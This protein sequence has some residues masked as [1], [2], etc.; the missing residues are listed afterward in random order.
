MSTETPTAATPAATPAPAALVSGDAPAAGAPPAGSSL[1]DVLY[2]ADA[3]PTADASVSASAEDPAGDEPEVPV[4]PA[5]PAL[6]ASDTAS[7]ALAESYEL[8]FP[9]AMQVNDALVTE[10]RTALAA[11]GVPKDKAQGVVDVYVHAQEAAA[12]AALAEFTSTQSAWEN[13]INAMPAFQGSTREKSLQAIGALLDEFGPEAKAGILNDPAVG[14]N[15]HLVS[16]L[17]KLAQHNAEGKPTPTGKPAPND[18][19]GKPLRGRTTAEIL[20]PNA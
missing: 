2:P 8:T 13:E 1:A 10:A 20:Y 15:P 7:A 12:A 5:Q 9:P 6:E 18:A 11:A 17:H 19:N 16:L 14:N 4:D 3:A